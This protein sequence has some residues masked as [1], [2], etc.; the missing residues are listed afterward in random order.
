MH[1]CV[2]RN[3]FGGRGCEQIQLRTE[4]GQNG[5]LRAVALLVSES[6]GSCNLV[7]EIS[8]RIVKIS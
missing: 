1:S 6:G 5:D 7:Q 8:F 3:F 2:P 4:D